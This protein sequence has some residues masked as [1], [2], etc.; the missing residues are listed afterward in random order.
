MLS[1]TVEDPQGRRV[2]VADIE[3][4]IN[5][6]WEKL[7]VTSNPKRAMRWTWAHAADSVVRRINEQ[8][9]YMKAG[10]AAFAK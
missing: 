2:F 7:Y 6:R 10:L 8:W 9:P 4:K 3:T 5:G 1:V